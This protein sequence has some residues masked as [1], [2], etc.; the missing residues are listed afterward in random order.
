MAIGCEWPRIVA[1]MLT[2]IPI[3]SY[4]GSFN[5]EYSRFISALMERE[6]WRGL[7]HRRHP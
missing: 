2:A 1:C 7:H 4:E 5:T 3:C 6:L